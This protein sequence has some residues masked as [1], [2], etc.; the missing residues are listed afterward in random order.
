MTINPSKPKI[1]VTGATGYVGGALTEALV[2]RLVPVRCLAR[3]LERARQLPF[4]NDVQWAKG[5]VTDEAALVAALAGIEIAYYLVHSMADSAEFAARDREAALTFGRAAARAGVRRIIYLGGLGDENE[6]LSEHL[7]SRHE[8]GTC[9][10]AAGV[11]VVEFRASVVLG[12]GSISF[13]MIRNLV[14]RLPIMITPRWVEVETQPIAIRDLLSYLIAALTLPFG[15]HRIYEIGGTD[16]VT[17]GGLMREYARQRG[18]RRL[19]IRVPVLTPRLSSLWVALVTP[20]Y[21]RVGRR[22]IESIRHP[23]VVRDRRAQADFSVR[24]IG[25]RDA[26]AETIVADEVQ[27]ARFRAG[28]GEPPRFGFEIDR[29][30][31]IVHEASAI[32]FAPIRRI[33]GQRGWYAYDVLWKIRGALDRLIGG[34]G[35]RRGRRDPEQLV[36]GEPLDFWRVEDVRENRRLLL[37]AEMKLPGR[38]WLEFDLEPVAGDPASTRVRQTAL[39]QPHGALG[40]LYWY[41]IL[42]LHRMIFAAMLTRIGALAREP[43]SK[44]PTPDVRAQRIVDAEAA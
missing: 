25:L 39:F 35:M 24:P 20:L 12:P 29:R 4:A 5:D 17:Y 33:G 43:R 31:I 13:E 28:S 11:E 14:E 16:V 27:L 32:A 3:D 38:A 1:L 7:H 21:A 36:A 42:P 22:L 40:F 37:K 18:L 2:E 6:E 10:R 30:E 23:T 34:V 8:T 9:L 41:A 15:D 44:S 26:V 19:L